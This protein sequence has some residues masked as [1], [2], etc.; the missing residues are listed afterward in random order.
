MV[1]YRITLLFYLSMVWVKF[2]TQ[3]HFL[4]TSLSYVFHNRCY[5]CYKYLNLIIS[6]L[7][8]MTKNWR[9][10][11]S[12]FTKNNLIAIGPLKVQFP[13][14]IPSVSTSSSSASLLYILDEGGAPCYRARYLKQKGLRFASEKTLGSGLGLVTGNADRSLLQL[15]F[16]PT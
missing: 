12:C 16:P 10:N 1:C 13:S 11:S 6:F 2:D 9:G 5:T 14:L 4:N 7:R 3:Q 8:C 15:Q